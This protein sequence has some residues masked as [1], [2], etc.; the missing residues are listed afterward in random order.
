MLFTLLIRI[1]EHPPMAD[2]EF[3]QATSVIVCHPERSEGSVSM[4]T[5]IL[6]FAQDDKTDFGR[7]CS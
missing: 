6:R 4:G 3:Y 5:E 1:P 7:Y 2:N